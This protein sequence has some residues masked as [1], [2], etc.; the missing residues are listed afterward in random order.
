MRFNNGE[1][2]HVDEEAVI[3]KAS[4]ELGFHRFEGENQ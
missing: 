1:E 3:Q 4:R 2:Q